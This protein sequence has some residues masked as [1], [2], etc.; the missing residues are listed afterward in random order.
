MKISIQLS[1]IENDNLDSAEQLA[2]E[3]RKLAEVSGLSVSIDNPLEDHEFGT[4]QSHTLVIQMMIDAA[5]NPIVAGLISR[6]L[7]EAI[8]KIIK[9]QKPEGKH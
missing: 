6:L 7:S 3:V 4:L 2:A 8:I 1:E 9:D 5:N